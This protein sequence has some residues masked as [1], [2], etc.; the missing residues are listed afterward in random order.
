MRSLEGALTQYDYCL[1][2]RRNLDPKTHIKEDYGKKEREKTAIHEPGTEAWDSP[3]P[4][5]LRRNQPG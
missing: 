5:A 4:T 1:I 2:K 3:F